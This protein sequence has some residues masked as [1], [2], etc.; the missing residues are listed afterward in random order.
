MIDGIQTSG[1]GIRAPKFI[2]VLK[3]LAN[4]PFMKIC[5]LD[6]RQKH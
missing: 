6:V 1:K 4:V 2:Q 3:S 5:I